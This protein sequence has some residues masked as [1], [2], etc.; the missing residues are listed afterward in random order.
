MARELQAFIDSDEGRRQFELAFLQRSRLAAVLASVAA[1]H[2]RADGWTL[3]SVAGAQLN[4]LIPEEFARLK[5]V[6]GEG[7]LNKLIAALDLFE[8]RTED[9]PNGGTRA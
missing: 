8:V 3:L 9:T 2:A 4:S 6:R 1:E 7:S 5:A